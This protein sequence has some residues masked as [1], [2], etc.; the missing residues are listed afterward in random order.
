MGNK[1]QKIEQSIRDILKIAALRIFSKNEK[2]AAQY[3]GN[4][5]IELLQPPKKEFGDFSTNFAMKIAKDLKINPFETARKIIAYI[6]PN[7]NFIEKVEVAGPGFINFYLNKQWIYT[8][9]KEI[10]KT[11]ETYGEAIPNSKEY[12]Q[13]EFVSANPTGPLHIG[14]GRGAAVGSVLVNILKA[15]GNKVSTEY[16]INDA[17]QQ[18]DN[19]A[20]SVNARYLELLRQPFVF[21]KDGYYGEDIYATAHKII[22]KDGDKYLGFEESQRIQIFKK[23]AYKEKLALLE[24]DLKE[25]GVTFDNWFSEKELYKKN[26]IKDILEKLKKSG[27]L[28]EQDGA[29]WIRSSTFGDDKDRVLIRSDGNPT[30]ITPDISYHCNKFER[31]FDRLIN[32]LGADHHGYVTRMKAAM[33]ALGFDTSRLEI[34]LLQMVRLFKGKELVKLSKRIGNI[35]TLKELIDEVGK[36]AARYFFIMRSIDSQLD[37][38]I[39]L[40]IKQSNE[41]PVY[42]IQYAYARICSIFRQLEIEK[43]SIPDIEKVDLSSLSLPIEIDIIKKIYDYP[44]KISKAADFRA[45]H[46]IA[47]YVLELA[48]LFH[49]FYNQCRIIGANTKQECNS[50]IILIKVVKNCL[51]HSLN[52]LGIRALESM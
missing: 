38:D 1:N 16:Y 35:I 6:S 37:F 50:R 48:E 41:N 43:I 2:S 27:N 8:G 47:K 46:Y 25:F 13:I 52:I 20:L 39:D 10:Y 14:H 3:I 4:R 11:G 42:Y 23:I 40:A 19:L 26:K 28:Y 18:I 21:P 44:N 31:G 24:K 30:Y 33:A 9:L 22:E 7:T 36:D 34:L 29:K 12:I 5:E 15:A 32:I 17:G 49:A 45:P 51:K